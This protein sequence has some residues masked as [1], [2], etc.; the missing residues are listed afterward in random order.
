MNHV[1]AGRWRKF[2][3]LA[4]L[5]AGCGEETVPSPQDPTSEI[6]GELHAYVMDDF[7]GRKSREIYELHDETG[8]RIPLAGDTARLSRV[9]PGSPIR[10]AGRRKD[11]SFVIA[12][13]AAANAAA[14][15]KSQPLVSSPGGP[16]RHRRADGGSPSNS[17]GDDNRSLAAI[18]VNFS[19]K[20][21]KYSNS[22]LRSI[23][24]GSVN[25]VSEYYQE[26]SFGKLCFTGV[27][28]G[29][30]TVDISQC[31]VVTW[32]DVFDAAYAAA[33]GAGSDVSSYDHILCVSPKNKNWDFV[34]MAEVGTNSSPQ[35]EILVCNTDE[36][37][38][39]T[40]AH[41][42][43]H[44]LGIHHSNL[45]DKEYADTSSVMGYSDH[46]LLHFN[47][48]HKAYLGW[49]PQP[50][51]VSSAGLF[52]VQRV[53]SEA[54]ADQT[55]TLFLSRTASA[56]G[57]GIYATYRVPVCNDVDRAAGYRYKVLVHKM[58]SD[59]STTLLATLGKYEM[60]TSGDGT[61]AVWVLSTYADF[62]WV[63]AKGA[64]ETMNVSA[65][66]K[67]SI[68]QAE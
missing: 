39:S 62:A 64:G 19:D 12:D 50:K 55:Q 46:H 68:S 27:V 59:R 22:E 35:D 24:F 54:E 57:S 56:D 41:E 44:N 60:W 5:L 1:A 7:Q 34:G 42:I 38:V 63:W 23:L 36:A 2:G 37:D 6:S 18:I 48:P 29:P 58:D 15:T 14:S 4:I 8:R 43:G 16:L 10:L 25:S 28:L 13:G 33:A 53:E 47:A 20:S 11:R 32:R 52:S 65:H 49:I 26:Q 51:T 17:I 40:F 66:R 21:C 3:V 61:C 67:E 45:P 31:D 9:T 30:Y